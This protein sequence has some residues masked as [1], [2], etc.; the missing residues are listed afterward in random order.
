MDTYQH[1]TPIHHI[2]FKDFLRV[3]DSKT[4]LF[5]MI[6]DV[7]TFKCEE[8]IFICT[9]DDKVLANRRIKSN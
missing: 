1:V 2:K 3:N 9:E 8:G 6:A 4:E 7:V 5:K